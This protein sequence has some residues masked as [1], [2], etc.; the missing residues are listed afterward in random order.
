MNWLAIDFGTSECSAAF[1]NSD[2]ELKKIKFTSPSPIS[3]YDFPTV[4]WVDDSNNI[5]VGYEANSIAAKDYS[6]YIFEFKLDILQECIIGIEGITY[7]D[8]ITAI[9]S[10]IKRESESEKNGQNIFSGVIITVPVD[11]DNKAIY[12]LRKSA[13]DA[14][15]TQVETVTEPQAAA[16]YFNKIASNAY[17][18]T[19]FTA[20]IYD[21]GGGTFDPAIIKINT[22]QDGIDFSM[23]IAGNGTKQAGRYF[24]I[25]I[26]DYFEERFPI[27]CNENRSSINRELIKKCKEDIKNTLSGEMQA[28][29]IINYGSEGMK[30]LTLTRS[31]FNYMIDAAISDSITKCQDLINKD[32]MQWTDI[33]AIFFVGGSC[34]IPYVRERIGNYARNYNKNIKTIW[35]SVNQQDLDPQYAVSLGAALYINHLKATTMNAKTYT[36]KRNQLLGILSNILKINDLSESSKAEFDQ[37]N[38]KCLEDQF[39]IVLVGEFQGGKSTTF[40]TFCDGREISPRGAMVKT[41]AC[42]ITARNLSDKK[43]KECAVVTWKTE[44]EII[45]NIED[46]LSKHISIENDLGVEFR[47]GDVRMYLS[48]LL[49][50]NNKKHIELINSAINKEWESYE[51]NRGQYSSGNLDILRIATLISRFIS[52]NTIKNNVGKESR[53]TVENVSNV[54]VFPE[55]W[56]NRWNNGINTRFDVN[57]ILFAF[58]ASV[59]CYLHSPNLE[60]LGCSITDCPGLFASKWD[61]QVALDT[62]PKADAILY[63]L[64][65]DK[66]IGDGD[67]DS[68][69]EIQAMPSAHKKIYFSINMRAPISITENSIIPTDTGKI[70]NIGFKVGKHDVHKYHA[71]LAFLATIGDNCLSGNLT[72]DTKNR[73]LLLSKRFLGVEMSFDDAWSTLVNQQLMLIC[74]PPKM[75]SG[76]SLESVELIRSISGYEELFDGIENFIIKN[77]AESILITNGA[78]RCA[79]ALTEIENTLK[80]RE[81]EAIQDVTQ[82]R[83]ELTVA[84]NQ[85]DDFHEEARRIVEDTFNESEFTPLTNDFYDNIMVESVDEISAIVAYK[86]KKK[87][88]ASLGWKLLWKNKDNRAQMMK[89][90][91]L[92]IY[93]NAMDTALC[94]RIKLWMTSLERGE[95]ETYNFSISKEIKRTNQQIIE[96]WS[97]VTQ[98]NFHFPPLKLPDP[99]DIYTEFEGNSI[100]RFDDSIIDSMCKIARSNLVV[101]IVLNIIFSPILVFVWIEQLFDYIS[102]LI[103]GNNTKKDNVVTD[104][105]KIYSSDDLS[106]E[107]KVLYKKVHQQLRASF[108][109]RETILKVKNGIWKKLLIKISEG[110]KGFYNNSLNEQKE[111]FTIDYNKCESN[112]NKSTIEREKVA[113]DA[114]EL[115]EGKIEPYNKEVKAFRMSTLKIL[116]VN[117]K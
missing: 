76:I 36:A 60:R 63:L 52:D 4:A 1:I 13:N 37:I 111:K 21:L 59:D 66:A 54:I 7:S 97:S 32:G 56:E 25:Q 101:E 84:K 22:N 112:L 47:P 28:T 103:T 87:L 33:D 117:G 2:G 110:L 77:K 114:R 80:N 44:R 55:D 107:E 39:N 42:K 106:E 14:G 57:E 9:L 75:V 64:K 23:P 51:K 104:D 109:D 90:I 113:D 85:L 65:G 96:K 53:Y 88:T 11:F 93:Q 17:P 38:K 105:K 35:N 79:F 24:D 27:P 92:P 81:D 74:M 43:Q 116:G 115:R 62:I 40:N 34:N 41:S 78:D 19:N 12:T 69:K 95:N 98:C 8:I 18:K 73:F 100:V 5:Y 31:E 29:S 94:K 50:F 61:T 86:L 3:Q 26:K 10:Q 91:A 20:L 70:N 58:V 46:V 45:L 71:L 99:K 108:G 30:T 83:A 6:K 67:T 48:D 102:D 89:N 16:I 82:K 72:E 15:F 49:H 68:L